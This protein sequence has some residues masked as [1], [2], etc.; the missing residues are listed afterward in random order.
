[1]RWRKWA[2]H[3]LGGIFLIGSLWLVA[4]M[5][6][7]FNSPDENANYWF[8]HYFAIAEIPEESLNELAGNLIHPRSVVAN[9]EVLLPG[10][11]LGLPMAFGYI[12]KIFNVFGE[13]SLV[14]I[15]TP[16]IAI[17]GVV[18]FERL[19][20]DISR[21]SHIA[22]LSALLL[23]FHP[24]YWYYSARTMMHNV[25][26]LAVL[27]A[28]AWFLVSRP[29]ESAETHKEGESGWLDMALAGIAIAA[30]LSLRTSEALWVLAITG[31]YIAF[32]YFHKRIKA[33]DVAVFI[34][35]FA[36]A[37]IPMLWLQMELY[38]A[39]FTNGYTLGQGVADSAGGAGGA[40][41]TA[42][43]K[44]IL[45]PFGIHELAS[46]RNIWR[47]GFWL[48]PWISGLAAIGMGI[49]SWRAFVQKRSDQHNWK[50]L[51]ITTVALAAW[52]GVVYGS[53]VFNDNPDPR[54]VTI[55]NSYVRYW[56]PLFALGAPFAALAI[57]ELS[58]AIM[59]SSTASRCVMAALTSIYLTF[60][61]VL[62]FGGDDGLMAT[63][64]NLLEFQERKEQIIENTEEDAV[65]IV[66]MADKYL[67]PD[68]RVINTLRSEST[69]G[70]IPDLS[71]HV[72]L[73]YYG[74]SLP[75][76]ELIH[77]SS[78]RYLDFQ[79]VLV[80]GAETL[81]RIEVI[82]SQ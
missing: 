38:G 29:C 27:I 70:S 8:A 72:P 44:N 81:Y 18:I 75:E 4:G 35:S 43:I 40:S 12:G 22:R 7:I 78:A 56:L 41:I 71:E 54:A 24:A 39:L 47:Y 28:G 61:G 36:V 68:R 76:I 42:S 49:V 67:W 33:R 63:R 60:S 57:T 79:E 32:Q 51:L 10:S 14:L 53:W 73:Y 62:V 64:E 11:F 5:P 66:E 55:A 19:M 50:W 82:Q 3:I 48:F 13:F 23:L 37:M 46:L 1:M 21:S 58:K 80:I 74:I 6:T 16:V 2:T 20:R 59:L 52:L 26:F 17:I 34:I 45:F 69:Y 31:G 9:A 65:I 77:L 15:L 30:A 25:P